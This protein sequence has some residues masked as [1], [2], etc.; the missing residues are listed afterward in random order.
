MRRVTMHDV[1]ERSGVSLGTVSNVLN[2]PELVAPATREHVLKAIADVGFVRNNAARQLAAGRAQAIG[3]VTLDIDNPF[4]S[5]VA[6]GVEE[7]ANEAGLLVILC[8]SAGSLER[9][10]RQ[11][12]MLEEQRVAGIVV[13]PIERT[14]A[15]RIREVH[16]RGTP[17]VLLDR[18]RSARQWCS[19]AVDDTLGARLAAEHLLELGHRRIGLLNGPIH[20][21][22]CAERRESFLHVL[23]AHGL[24]LADGCDVEVGEMT[25]EAGERATSDMLGQKRLPSAIFCTNDLLALGAE[26]AALARGVRVPGEI[27]LVGYD[28]IRFAASSL[29]P[30]TTLRMPS[31]QLGY[32]GTKLLIDEAT[33]GTGHKH[34]K[35]LFEPELVIREST[36]GA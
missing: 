26:R 2:K 15:R 1:A 11:V 12:G 13:S 36:T 23:G 33:E 28:D 7:A 9:E 14:P 3:L 22:P 30:L 32:E 6:R 27:A 29:V 34:R 10:E 20:L 18:H 24:E 19:A 35:L 16:A 21:T 31:F 5:E 4:F 25:I 17:V 8:S